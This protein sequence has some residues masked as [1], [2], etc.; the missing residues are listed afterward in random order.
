MLRV[1]EA[2]LRTK[3]DRPEL[4][5]SLESL[6]AGDLQGRARATA[7]RALAMRN[8]VTAGLSVKTLER[9]RGSD[10][11]ATAL[12]ILPLDLL[13]SELRIPDGVTSQDAMLARQIESSVSYIQHGLR[14][15]LIDVVNV[16][17]LTP[18]TGTDRAIDLRS[19][20]IEGR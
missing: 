11:A 19:P 9:R 2:E 12:D 4:T 7:A 10:M 6:R 8:L 3:L 5:L 17:R 20:C 13:K 15:P 1:A 14:A 18:V 16:Y